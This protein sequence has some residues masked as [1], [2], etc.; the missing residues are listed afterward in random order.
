MKRHIAIASRKIIIV[1]K[2]TRNIYISSN[3][4]STELREV[5]RF[6]PLSEWGR[7]NLN[8]G[9]LHQGLGTNELIVRCIVHDVQNA[10]LPCNG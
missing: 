5:V 7:V 8:N 10:R 3:I 1:I 6:K 4:Y 2:I 9:V